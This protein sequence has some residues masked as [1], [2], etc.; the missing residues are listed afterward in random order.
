MLRITLDVSEWAEENF[1][2][3]ELGDTR[4]TRRLVQVARQMAEHPDGSTPDQAESWG[5]L[6]AIYRLFSEEDVTFRALAEPHWQA[7]R[8]RA[9]GIVLLIGDTSETDFGIHR[10]TT[11]LGPT[12]DGFGRGF[13]LQSSLMVDA[14]TEK[15]LGLAGQE[16]FWRKP[17]RKKENSYQASQRS[18]E[19][20][21]WGRVI[22]LIGP[23]TSNVKYVHVFDHGADNREVFCHLIRQKSD[24][25]IRAAQ[26]HRKV[27]EVTDTD[28]T[29]K[30]VS[31]REVLAA[32]PVLGTYKL[33]VRNTGQQTESWAQIEV[34]RVQIILPKPK[35]VTPYEKAIGVNDLKQWVVEAREVNAPRDVTALHWVLWTSLPISTFQDAWEVIRDDEC[36]WLIE[37]FH[38]GIKTG[39]RLESRQYMTPHSLESAAALSS[40][41]A[42]R[43]VQLKTVARKHP[44]VPAAQVIP[45]A[46]LRMLQALRETPIKNVRD[47]YRHLA[48]LGG[49]L[50]RKRDGE[51]GWITLW[52]GTDKLLLAIRGHHA[53]T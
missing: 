44:D 49:F 43:L 22:D 33:K 14:S 11:G 36:R 6:Q 2:N 31:L 9:R 34:R 39:C 3:C 47:F 5:D 48:G 13:F 24:W 37:E 19:S 23:P 17:A 16:I 10:N 45:P 18:R 25:V 51:P 1:S 28:S 26:L 12:G 15:I 52:R 21:T 27:Q 20:E 29:G 38:K 32:Q 41:L 53:F 30:R 35:R 50:M 46:W 7:T 4:R 40:I 42:V 8:R